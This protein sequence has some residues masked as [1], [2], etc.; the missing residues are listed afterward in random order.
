MVE[1]DSFLLVQVK[2]CQTNFRS[3]HSR[4]VIIFIIAQL[5]FKLGKWWNV[6]KNVAFTFPSQILT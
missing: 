4:L 1:L 2:K 3:T 5:Y 6:I